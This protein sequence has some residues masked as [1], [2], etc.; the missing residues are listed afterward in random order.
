[1]KTFLTSDPHERAE[2]YREEVAVAERR[3]VD[4]QDELLAAQDKLIRMKAAH[5][6]AL[7]A[8]AN[9]QRGAPIVIWVLP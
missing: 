4:A 7:R 3:L 5:A 2:M 6:S 9:A 1:M 8:I